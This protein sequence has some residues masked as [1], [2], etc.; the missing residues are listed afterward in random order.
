VAEGVAR[1]AGRPGEADSAVLADDVRLIRWAGPAFVLFSVILL[2]WS[3]Y[4]GFS[5]PSR[6][7]SPHYDIAWAGFDGLLMA[8]LACTGYFALRRSAFLALTAAATATL[9]VVDAWFDNITSPRRQLPGAIISAVFIELP[10]AALCAW[11]SY[12]TQQL[13]ERR[14][15]LLLRRRRTGRVRDH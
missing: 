1:P 13:Q 5:L 12:H 15:V 7:L 9:L 4:L 8:A 11:L 3:I 10:L 14:I 6:Q 2:P